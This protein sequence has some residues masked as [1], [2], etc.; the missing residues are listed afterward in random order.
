LHFPTGNEGKIPVT[1]AGPDKGFGVVKYTLILR[2]WN[3]IR[4]WIYF[5]RKIWF[6]PIL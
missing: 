2:I 4:G 6:F 3:G 1:V 5:H